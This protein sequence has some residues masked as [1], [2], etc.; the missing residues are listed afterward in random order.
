MLMESE[1]SALPEVLSNPVRQTLLRF[2]AHS[3]FSP[4]AGAWAR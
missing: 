1:E 3:Q 2:I 4:E